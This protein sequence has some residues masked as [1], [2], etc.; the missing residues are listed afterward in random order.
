MQKFNSIHTT[1]LKQSVRYY[2]KQSFR[3]NAFKVSQTFKFLKFLFTMCQRCLHLVFVILK[4]S[5]SQQKNF[6]I[7]EN[8]RVVLPLKFRPFLKSEFG[9]N[10][11]QLWPTIIFITYLLCYQSFSEQCEHFSLILYGTVRKVSGLPLYLCAGVI[12]HHR[13]GGILQSNPHLNE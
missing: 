11:I 5:L 6:Q 7:F 9:E 10:C 1:V 3:K 2:W 12:L 8:S 13:A 4:H